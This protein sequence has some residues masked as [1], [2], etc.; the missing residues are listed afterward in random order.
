MA[1]EVTELAESSE[2]SLPLTF[3]RFFFYMYSQMIKEVVP[4]TE[5]L[6]DASNVITSHPSD[7]SLSLTIVEL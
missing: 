7:D 3:K 1:L 5:W 6:S 2:A 4:S